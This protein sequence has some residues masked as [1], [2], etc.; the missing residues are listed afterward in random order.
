MTFFFLLLFPSF[1]HEVLLQ[2][3]PCISILTKLGNGQNIYPY[4]RMIISTSYKHF[5]L[6]NHLFA[7]H[8]S[9]NNCRALF[10]FSFMGGISN[11]NL[12]PHVLLHLTGSVTETVTRSMVPHSKFLGAQLGNFERG[13]RYIDNR[14]D[15]VIYSL[16]LSWTSI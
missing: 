5:V 11:T 4:G 10:I 15:E 7:S 14:K 2:I 12:F 13:A 16:S 6:D 3:L 8:F 1:F 9:T